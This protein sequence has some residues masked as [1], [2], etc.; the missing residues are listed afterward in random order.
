[1]SNGGTHFS[2]LKA[3][4][5]LND[6]KNVDYLRVGHGDSSCNRYIQL[7]GTFDLI[8]IKVTIVKLS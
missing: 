6:H 4:A 7:A 3:M 2:H 1:M 8:F 5:Y